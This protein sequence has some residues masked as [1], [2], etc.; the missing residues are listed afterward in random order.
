MSTDNGQQRRLTTEDPVSME[1]LNRLR[2]LQESRLD[3]GDRFLT[4]EQE[5]VKLLAAARRVDEEKQRVFEALLLERGL[6][7]DATV[8]I[9]A[10]TGK[11]KLV[12]Q[13]SEPANRPTP[14]QQQPPTP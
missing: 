7:P 9:D 13:S 5:Q 3:I 4:L 8:E 6:P 10:G 11:I 1:Q 2:L 12:N 14:P